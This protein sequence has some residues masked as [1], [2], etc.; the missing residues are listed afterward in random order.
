MSKPIKYSSYLEAQAREIK[1]IRSA[2][3]TRLRL[4]AATARLL[5]SSR[6]D[7][8][9]VSDI[10]AEAGLAKGTFFIYFRT[11]D[12]AIGHLLREYVDFERGTMPGFDAAGIDFALVRSF[13]EWYEQTFAVNHG[14]ISCLV[15]LSNID[16][17]FRA[18]WLRRNQVVI[19]R[20]AP[21]IR[22]SLGIAES[23]Y[24]LLDDAL[25]AVGSI[26]DQSLF[27]RYGLIA[28]EAERTS[29]MEASIELHA[30]LMFRAIYGRNPPAE[31]LHYVAGLLPE[32]PVTTGTAASR[33]PR[34]ARVT[35]S[36]GG[37][38]RPGR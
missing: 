32:M 11:K 3:K 2:T 31:E 19:E 22:G 27:A 26:M 35:R 16:R 9:K 6:F 8:L 30:L 5:D 38:R 34:R 37:K 4:L 29:S 15:R 25:H 33:V 1:G 21:G 24:S 7:D 20:V 23:G 36:A 17:D 12:E 18:L 28:R 14:V 13:T 10:C